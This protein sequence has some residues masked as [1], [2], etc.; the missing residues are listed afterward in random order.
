MEK[1][2]ITLFVFTRESPTPTPPKKTIENFMERSVWNS[3]TAGKTRGNKN[4]FRLL[5]VSWYMVL[6]YESV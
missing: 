4:E 5:V 6:F 2:N 3:N 1:S